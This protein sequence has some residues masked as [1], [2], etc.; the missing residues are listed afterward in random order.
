MI[1][2]SEEVFD[3]CNDVN[4]VLTG[5]LSQDALENAF[6][7]VR[8]QGNNSHPSSVPTAR[9]SSLKNCEDDNA[10]YLL[11]ENATTFKDATINT[12]NVQINVVEQFLKD[13]NTV[14]TNDVE[15]QAERY[16]PWFHAL[17]PEDVKPPNIIIIMADDMGFD[18]V[19]FRGNNEF[20]TPNIDALAYHGKILQ[21]LYAP[22]MCTPSRSSLLTG[23]Y[24]IHTGTQH[25]V[26]VN[27]E[28]WSILANLNHTLP[29][30]L[31]RH[32]YSTN[33]VGKWHMGMGRR[34]YTPTYNGFDY[35][36]GYWGAFVDYYRRTCKMP[37][38]SSM[39]YDFR[40]NLD[41]E[42]PEPGSYVTDLLTSEAERIIME[43]SASKKPLFLLVSH[44]ATH[45]ANDDD[46]LQA[47]DEEIEKFGYIKDEKKR[48]YAAMASKLDESVGR[49]V[50]ALDR[51]QMLKNSIVLFFSDN[52]APSV[53]LYHNS[54]SNWPLKGQK[55]SPWE[56]ALRVPGAIWSPLLANQGTIF[57]PI[58][59]M[60]DWLPTLAAA[61]NIKMNS[62]L[63]GLNMWP[64]LL[65][66]DTANH[67]VEK[68]REIVHMLDDIWNLTSY[69]KGR[70]KYVRGTTI[71]G[72]YDSVLLQRD[73][74]TKDPRSLKYE[75]AIQT[76]EVSQSLRKFD[77]KPL[78][79]LE[80]R[81]LRA[82]AAVKCPS[83]SKQTPCN[84]TTEECLYDIRQDPCEQNNLAP[85][86]E[87]GNVLK[88]LRKSVE[89]LRRKAL[90]PKT[91]GSQWSYDP[92]YHDCTWSNFLEDKPTET[93][94]QCSYDTLPC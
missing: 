19:S 18:D 75:E 20:L 94:L 2:L 34:E 15:M 50:K 38:N 57:Q 32:G 30:V 73:P 59:Y 71:G 33:L 23:L 14:Q 46:P 62:S 11:C 22:P 58:I 35:H 85:L 83:G 16:V 44:M 31:Q 13:L 84:A 36:Y 6:S 17:V 92:G 45:A 51:A 80:I 72:I 74:L 67:K 77:R 1:L 56:G 27:E 12:N 89:R 10:Q 9:V 54:G 25:F 43:N 65:V 47:P 29:K 64:D 90:P 87:Y 66:S 88:E 81:K 41:L 79:S 86:P 76:S 68:D 49:I 78:T 52:G 42:C 40:R 60:A 48:I 61:A 91:G 93:M 3:S 26:L 7:T 69:M 63:D 24:P 28:P 70:Y 37:T 53:G 82:G 4:Y 8:A 5:K 39:G 55:N 21:R